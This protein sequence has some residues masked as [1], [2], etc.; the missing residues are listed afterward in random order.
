MLLRPGPGDAVLSGVFGH[1][2][3]K[4]GFH[5]CYQHQLGPQ[6]VESLHRYEVD[7]VVEEE[8]RARTRASPQADPHPLGMTRS[9]ADPRGPLEADGVNGVRSPKN[10]LDCLAMVGSVAAGL[11]NALEPTLR[12]DSF[13]GKLQELILQRSGA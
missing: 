13:G 3:M 1:S 11:T 10:S 5:N 7:A 12:E 8:R 2:P 9:S 4:A 6:L